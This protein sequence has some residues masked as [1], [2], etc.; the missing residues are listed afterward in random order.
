MNNKKF[1]E[2][3]V[4]TGITIVEDKWG[5]KLIAAFGKTYYVRF[6]DGRVQGCAKMTP[7]EW[8]WGHED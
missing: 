1:A 2:K 6:D 8:K 5:D 3:V 4:K 7:D